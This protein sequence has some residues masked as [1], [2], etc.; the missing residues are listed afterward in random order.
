MTMMTVS[1]RASKNCLK[2]PT[3]FCSSSAKQVVYGV[4]SAIEE[5]SQA[6]GIFF[7]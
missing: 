5:R 4:D 7:D 1:A 3:R 6:F 2:M